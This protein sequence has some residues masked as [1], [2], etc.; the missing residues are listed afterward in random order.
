MMF[1][2]FYLWLTIRI[3]SLCFVHNICISYYLLV[4]RVISQK[5]VVIQPLL[6]SMSYIQSFFSALWMLFQ[7]IVIFVFI[8]KISGKAMGPHIQ[9]IL[10]FRSRSTL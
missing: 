1:L 7:M 10:G 9:G 8:S 5:M 6:C 4:C 2:L 3:D